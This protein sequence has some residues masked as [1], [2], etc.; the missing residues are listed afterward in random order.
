MDKIK[1]I[2]TD[3]EPF[4]RKGLQGY[5]AQIDFLDLRGVCENAV[6]LNSL[7]KREPVDLLFLDIEMPYMTGIDFLKHF[8]GAPKVIFTTA[9]DQYAIEAIRASALDYL[10]KPVEVEDLTE[11]VDR[12]MRKRQQP[13]GTVRI[14]TLLHNL[15]PGNKAVKRIAIPSLEGY[16]FVDID[17]IQYL[18]AFSNYT[19]MYLH[20]NQ[21]ITVS[22][23]L[24]DFEE[25]LPPEIF[26]R[27]HHS[28]IIN[29]DQVSRYIKGEGGQ[30]VMNNGKV[31]D[32]ARR[33]KDDFLRAFDKL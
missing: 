25:L 3:D 8:P 15:I 18:E 22:R 19:V 29:M 9:Y 32:V 24:K 30:V 14:E 31:L 10:V 26:V 27:I 12:A 2:I 13:A 7:L 33:K 21:K 16:Q 17:H 23:T 4:A 1:C 20:G 28:H 5:A 11:A 6:E